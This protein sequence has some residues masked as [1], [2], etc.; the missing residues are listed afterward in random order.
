M[1]NGIWIIKKENS[2]CIFHKSFSEEKLDQ[3]LFSGF[4]SGMYSFS[5]EVTK[6]GGLEIMELKD[7]RL[8]YGLFSD[9]IFIFAV[10]KDEDVDYLRK[11]IADISKEFIEKYGELLEDWKGDVSIF[12]PFERDLSLILEKI[13]PVNFIEVAT[14]IPQKKRLKLSDEEIQILSFCDGKT[15]VEIIASKTNISEFE[16]NRILSKWEKKKIIQRKMVMRT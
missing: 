12:E 11:K 15:P 14:K 1:I 7:M 2:I 13:R 9:L 10:T 4:L 6:T 5:E 8:L 16:L 3:D